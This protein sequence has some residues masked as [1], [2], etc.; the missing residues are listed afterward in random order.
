MEG[1]YIRMLATMQKKEMNS[2]FETIKPTHSKRFA[3]FTNAFAT[4][5]FA[6][7]LL[8]ATHKRRKD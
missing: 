8:F 5:K 1:K 2:R 7:H 3:N 4:L 6:T